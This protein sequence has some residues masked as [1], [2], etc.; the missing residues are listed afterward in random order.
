MDRERDPIAELARLIT[1][2]DQYREGAAADNRFHWETASER[3]HNEPPGLS[4]APQLPADLHAPEQAYELDECGHDDEAYDVE[5]QSSAGDD[6]RYLRT[7]VPRVRRRSLALMIAITGL[8]LMGT[9]GAFGYRKMFGG[10]VFRRPRRS[11]QRA[12]SRISSRPPLARRKPKT[13]ATLAKTVPIPPARSKNWSR[14]K[15]S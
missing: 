2:A 14:A 6:E 7:E 8:A 4:P 10:S 5:D 3:H 15:S 9:A 13:A 12:T 11:S 1:Q